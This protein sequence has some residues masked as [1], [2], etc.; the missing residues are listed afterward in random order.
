MPTSRAAEKVAGR[1]A[2]F[3]ALRAAAQTAQS[4]DTLSARF[5]SFASTVQTRLDTSNGTGPTL[6]G[7]L[8]AQVDRAL[9]QVLRQ[10]PANGYSAAGGQGSVGGYSAA[11]GQGPAGGY[12]AAG[13]AL[14][15]PVAQA[16]SVATWGGGM[17]GPPAIAPNQA[18]LLREGTLIKGD[19]LSVLDTL[20]PLSTFADPS[21]LAAVTAVVRA[22]ITLL[23]E[24]F[25]RTSLQPRSQRV[26]V[27]LGGLLGFNPPSSPPDPSFGDVGALITLLN[28]GGPIV[29]TLLVDQQVAGQQV[30]TSDATQFLSQ[31]LAYIKQEPNIPSLP[32]DPRL[33]GRLIGGLGS[34][35]P[36]PGTGDTLALGPPSTQAQFRI[37]V[38]KP[39]TLSQQASLSYAE[40]LI[41]ADLLLPIVGQDASR[42]AGALDAIG[43][44]Q[45]EQ[46]TTF[47]SLLSLV[48]AD[49][50]GKKVVPNP[51]DE[52][53]SILVRITITD[54]L[55]WTSSMA[56][57]STLDLVR[58]AGQLGLNLIADQADE[59]FWL[60]VAL[61]QP[62][63][64]AGTQP[65]AQ[66]Q[67]AELGDAQ[68]Q[69]ELLTLARDLNL[70]ANLAV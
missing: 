45:G 28:L 20:Q 3:N 5:G 17:G 24:E 55:D 25:S 31:W 65:A 38:I 69:T 2:S 44:S 11:G 39:G 14:A 8:E 10:A 27:L 56:D 30:L 54:I 59:L 21:D 7:S 50:L 62:A 49:L 23:I 1:Q 48:D 52:D 15:Q 35:T 46:E 22:E 53:S 40:K 32:W 60:V 47:P 16:L 41:Q 63:L 33:K 51:P 43:L 4:I 57:A 6:T 34:L 42:V 36:Q 12:P 64:P 68:V 58:Q 19:M 66:D 61:L 37:A 26:R 29:P 67:M 70:L 18:A 13:Q 9:S